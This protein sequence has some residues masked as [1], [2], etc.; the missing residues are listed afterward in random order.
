MTGAPRVR[1]LC[2]IFVCVCEPRLARELQVSLARVLLGRA[3]T[4]L[5]SATWWALCGTRQALT[6]VL[7]SRQ[8]VAS[9]RLSLAGR[10]AQL[11]PCRSLDTSGNRHAESH[12]ARRM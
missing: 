1:L 6:A 11:L 5:G 8:G 12:V 7:E 9:A 3:R 4:G 2:S 10:P